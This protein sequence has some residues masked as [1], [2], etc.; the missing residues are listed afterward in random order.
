MRERGDIRAVPGRPFQP[1]QSGNPKGRPPGSRNKA[2]LAAE[3]L[4]EGEAEAITLKAMERAKAGDPVCIRLCM[5]RFSPRP[6]D[7]PLSFDL[8]PIENPE[9]VEKAGAALIAAIARG[10]VTALEA[11]PVMK[12]LVAQADLIAAGSYGRRL[13]ALEAQDRT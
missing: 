2:S 3:K 13:A 11:A 4:L 12:M 10:Q 9:G 1:G 8:P 7:R 6:R 5:D